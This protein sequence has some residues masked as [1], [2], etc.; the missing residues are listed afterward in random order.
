MSNVNFTFGS[1]TT[2][3]QGVGP[4]T[5]TFKPSN[6]TLS[7][8]QFISKVVYNLPN[9]TVTVTNDFVNPFPDFTYTLPAS[10]GNPQY[11]HTI[12]VSAFIGPSF[13]LPSNYILLA[14]ALSG[15]LTTNPSINSPQP[16]VFG[17]VHLLRTRSWGT[18][19]TT[20]FLLETNNPNYLLVNY[21]G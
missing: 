2:S 20:M 1:S 17:E 21:N 6:I 4:L 13:G 5:I 3:L 7:T 12:V 11:T 9:K 19:N 10:S 14:T 18:N 8:G 15:F 16:Y